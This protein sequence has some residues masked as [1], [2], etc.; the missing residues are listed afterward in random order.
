MHRS[1]MPRVCEL[2]D[3]VVDPNAPDAYFQGF[4]DVL[5]EVDS[6][7]MRSWL[8]REK[9]LQGLDLD[10]WEFLKGECKPTL[11]ARDAG[12]REWEQFISILNQARGY[13]YLVG[14]GCSE[15]QFIPRATIRS[16]KTPDI[17]GAIH[18]RRVLCEVKTFNI[19]DGEVASR[20]QRAAGMSSE[21]LD[22]GFFRKLA[23]TLQ[24]ANDQ[25]HAYDDS[26]DVLRVLFVV[27]NFDDFLG[28]HKA[29]YFEQIDA[30]IA[31]IRMPG[32]EVVFFNQRSAFH[33]HVSMKNAVVI[34]EAG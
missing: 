33:P 11:T 6:A 20:Q 30:K 24:G 23:A 34:N 9:E 16:R 28:E 19:S 7:K 17:R 12:G 10:A 4:D 29:E 31:S 5:R 32:S 15:V 14:L 26:E 27:T 22:E 8:V 1:D 2:R 21:R 3:L 25:M 13:N 18:G